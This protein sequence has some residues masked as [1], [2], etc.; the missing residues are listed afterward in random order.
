MASLSARCAR[1]SPGALQ[2]TRRSPGVN[3]DLRLTPFF[4]EHRIKTDTLQRCNLRGWGIP[5]GRRPDRRDGPR[6]RRS[7]HSSPFPALN[8]AGLTLV[9]EAVALPGNRQ[10]VRMM[11]QAIQEGRRQGGIL[12]EGRVPLAKR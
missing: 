10:D 5:E 9:L 7:I 12:R 4:R 8:H 11:P 1:P 6:A 3:A 2:S